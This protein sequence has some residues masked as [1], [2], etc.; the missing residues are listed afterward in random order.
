MSIGFF[1]LI[2]MSGS[3]LFLFICLIWLLYSLFRPKSPYELSLHPFYIFTSISSL[4]FANGSVFGDLWHAV[5]AYTLDIPMYDPTLNDLKII[6]NIFYILTMTTVYMFMIGRAYY[7][8]KGSKYGLSISTIVFISLL[9]ISNFIVYGYNIFIIAIADDFESTAKLVR[10]TEIALVVIIFILNGSLLTLFIYKLRKLLVSTVVPAQI[11]SVPLLEI[12][13]SN[14]FD[15]ESRSVSPVYKQTVRLDTH[16][17]K[18][19]SIMTRHTV[20]CT[21]ALLLNIGLWMANVYSDFFNEKTPSEP[22]YEFLY[23][24]RVLDV[25]IYSM[26]IFFNFRFNAKFYESCC[27]CCHWIMSACCKQW[28]KSK[29]KSSASKH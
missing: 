10:E 1:T 12:D 13:D 28:T 6:A 7:T 29:I 4:L 9:I 14:S 11:L 19:I 2:F 25:V 21:L 17:E 27:C 23:S 22:V 20:L 18:L 15:D 16:Q 8:F 24:L 3:S 5:K 26:V